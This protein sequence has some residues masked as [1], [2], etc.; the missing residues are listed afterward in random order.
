[1]RY[2]NNFSSV[3]DV[4]GSFSEEDENYVKLNNIDLKDEEVLI[5]SYG[6]RSYEGDAIVLFSRDGKYYEAH[7]SHCSCNGL[8]GQ[9]SPEE[10]SMEALI[11]R[12]ENGNLE[13]MIEEHGEDF[14]DAFRRLVMFELFE[15]E[16]LLK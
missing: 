8:E 11:H 3:N 1:M 5:A 16:V 13:N 9:W 7:G 6:G 2:F 15:R 14:L 12:L 4:I 10:T